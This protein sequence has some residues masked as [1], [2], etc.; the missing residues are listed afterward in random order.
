MDFTWKYIRRVN[1]ALINIG[2]KKDV[3][4]CEE[5]SSVS[6]NAHVPTCQINSSIEEI[7]IT[8]RA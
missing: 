4:K 8:N 3:Q 6:K 5:Y 7:V 2:Q 1:R